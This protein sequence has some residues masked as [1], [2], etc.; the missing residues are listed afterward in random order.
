MV[1]LQQL[2]ELV[3]GRKGG[4]RGFEEWAGAL[5]WQRSG[6]GLGSTPRL[7]KAEKKGACDRVDP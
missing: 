7:V 4:A 1:D 2:P 5:D 3:V 6:S